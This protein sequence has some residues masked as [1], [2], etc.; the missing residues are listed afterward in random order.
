MAVRDCVAAESCFPPSAGSQECLCGQ[1]AT[2][3]A[4]KADVI[5][6]GNPAFVVNGPCADE[7]KAGSPGSTTNVQLLERQFDF[8]YPGGI[9]FGLLAFARDSEICT[10]EC[11]MQ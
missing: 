5:E 11:N 7:I 2:N 8:N 9:G 4:L 3:P 10:A 1:S 6:C